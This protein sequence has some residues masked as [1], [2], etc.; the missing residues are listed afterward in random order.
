MIA[1]RE[2]FVVMFPDGARAGYVRGTSARACA[3][4]AP[5]FRAAAVIEAFIDAMIAFASADRCVDRSH[6]FMTGWSM[7]GYLSHHSGCLREDIR[8]VGPHFGRNS[9]YPEVS[10]SPGTNPS[11]CPLRP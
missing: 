6:I 3:A 5:S 4:M 7:G 1:N 11:S 8:A 10:A 2:G 9:Q